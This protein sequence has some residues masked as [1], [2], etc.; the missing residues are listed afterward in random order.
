MPQVLSLKVTGFTYGT[1][2]TLESI[3]LPRGAAS[4]S[5]NWI[6]KGDRIVLRGGS[7]IMGNNIAGAGKITGL[8]TFVKQDN[9][10]ITFRKSGR[11]LEYYNESADTWDEVGTNIFPVGAV[12]EDVSMEFHDSST[13]DQIFVNS[14]NGVF[15]KIMLANPGS[16]TD[17]S[18]ST[19]NYK[20]FIKIKNSRTWLWGVK[21][22]ATRVYLSGVDNPDN[23]TTV[24]SEAYGTGNASDKTF[25]HTLA[26]KASGAK[27][28]CFLVTVT[29]GVETFTD[30]RDG[31]LTGS[32]GGTGTINYTTGVCSVTFNEAPAG[33]APITTTYEWEDCTN[34]GVA[35]F[36]YSLTERIAGTGFAWPQDGGPVRTIETYQGKEYC[37]HDRKTWVIDITHLDDLTTPD[38]AG[39]VFNNNGSTNLIYREH[40]GTPNQKSSVATSDGIYYADALGEVEPQLRIL[41]IP[42]LGTEVIPA[43]VSRAI[44]MGGYY[45][46][47]DLSGYK[48]DKSVGYEW[49]D[50]ILF[51]CRTTLATQN[52]TMFL[53]NKKSKAITRLD[54][55][56]NYISVNNGGLIIG[57]SVSGN[58]FKIFT[59]YDDSTTSIDNYYI[60]G[61]DDLGFKGEKRVKKF[62][63]KG[64]MGI[65]AALEIWASLD[66]GEFVKIGTVTS[67]SA[68][69]TTSDLIGRS[70]IGGMMIGGGS[71]GDEYVN[72]EKEFTWNSGRFNRVEIKFVANPDDEIGYMEVSE[73]EFFDI[74]LK[75][76]KMNTL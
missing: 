30:N 65:D 42:Y 32:A 12:D 74:R 51:S 25:A 60:T 56:A 5:K 28:T 21:G 10:S 7:I 13:G 46:G 23:W 71:E 14:P 59:G 8:K 9:T 1:I 22:D 20:G 2:D 4:D 53:I 67:D 47:I 39:D 69:Y 27:R 6:P 63:V 26:F 73:Y 24:T 3:S 11:K 58:V 75:S 31:T 37:I 19:K 76:R 18:D 48:F 40:V 15:I 52:D 68:D 35:D 36:S 44:K 66:K 16:Y 70:E 41:T 38:T 17:V 72:F 64:K 49:G 62:R 29:D 43:S 55:F 54:F 61:D 57:D 34:G 33:A 50:Y 45:Q